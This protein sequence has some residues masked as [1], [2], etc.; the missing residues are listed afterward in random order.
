MKRVHLYSDASVTPNS[1]GKGVVGYTAIFM[2]SP[3][4][5]EIKTKDMV[6]EKNIGSDLAELLGITLQ[7]DMLKSYV[8]RNK[9]K[10]RIYYL[11]CDNLI[12]IEKYTNS[13]AYEKLL[14]FLLEYESVAVLNYCHGN[15]PIHTL[16]HNFSNEAR[17]NVIAKLAEESKIK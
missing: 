7:I 3:G 15:N 2:I 13:L 1:Y 8:K 10:K 4:N 11:N 6:A 14:E 5:L 9:C 12:S 17:K 16:C